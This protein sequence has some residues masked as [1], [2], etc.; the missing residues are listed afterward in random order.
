[1]HRKFI[2]YAAWWIHDPLISSSA[3]SSLFY[4][5]GHIISHLVQARRLSGFVSVTENPNKGSSSVRE[6]RHNDRQENTGDVRK[7][8]RA[9]LW[10]ISQS[11]TVGNKMEKAL[12]ENER[13]RIPNLFPLLFFFLYLHD[14]PTCSQATVLLQAE[15]QVDFANTRGNDSIHSDLSVPKHYNY[16][17]LL[18]KA[19]TCQITV[20]EAELR[21]VAHDGVQLKGHRIHWVLV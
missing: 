9:R 4:L 5:W 13:I 1:M 17:K 15:S 12:T 2:L 21:H 18:I 11:K 10:E 7:T 14:L 20:L 16:L 8:Q 3:H 19:S 6:T